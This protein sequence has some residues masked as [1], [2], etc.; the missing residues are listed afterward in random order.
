MIEPTTE[1]EL[2]EAVRDAVGPLSIR[3]EAT[4]AEW[5]QPPAIRC[6]LRAYQASRCMSRAR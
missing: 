2:S 3:G 1:L 4:R 5:R 6:L